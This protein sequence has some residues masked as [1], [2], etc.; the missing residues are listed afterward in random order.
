L[1]ARLRVR[2]APGIPCALCFLRDV[3]SQNSD[4]L[5]RENANACHCE[6]RNDEAISSL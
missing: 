1:H 5:C 4:K 3:A 6:E 2:R